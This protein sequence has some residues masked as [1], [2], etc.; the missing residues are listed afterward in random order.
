MTS[1]R[2][3]EDIP[4]EVS[5]ALSR[6]VPASAPLA[7]TT[8]QPGETASVEITAMLVQI[9][10]LRDTPTDARVIAQRQTMRAALYEQ[11]GGADGKSAVTELLTNEDEV[12]QRQVIAQVLTAWA[13]TQP[14]EALAW[15]HDEAQDNLAA[16]D[17]RAT[18]E[19]YDKTFR[20]LAQRSP[21]SAASSLAAVE[22]SACRLRALSAVVLTAKESGNLEPTMRALTQN[23]DSLRPVEIALLNKLVGDEI[24]FKEWQAKVTVEA[25][26]KELV[27][28]L[29]RFGRRE[30]D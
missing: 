13:D 3:P 14:L 28:E 29:E 21:S 20:A 8:T 1:V 4:F 16:Q 15:L 6:M 27:V 10:G 11:F 18:P 25:E 2:Q 24:G 30:T 19:F 17:Y 9:R 23:S 26:Q 5:P 12:F 22:G 7:E